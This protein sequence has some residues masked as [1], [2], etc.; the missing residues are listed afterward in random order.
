MGSRRRKEL[1]TMDE[2]LIMLQLKVALRLAMIEEVRMRKEGITNGDEFDRAICHKTVSRAIISM[3]PEIGKKPGD[4]TDGDTIKLLKK[5][6]SQEKERSVYELSYLKEKDVEGKSVSEVKKLV[7]DTIQALGDK[8]SSNLIEIAQ[9]YL[10]AQASEEEII[11]WINENLDLTQF[12]NKMQA[13][14][15][16]MKEFKGCDGNVVKNILISI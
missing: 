12:K 10:P 3:C 1:T 7:S 5:Y 16:I 14:G 8:L 6:I 13:M 4:V 9:E 11:K 15:P 2:S